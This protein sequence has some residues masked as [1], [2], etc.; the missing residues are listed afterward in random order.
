MRG[1]VSSVW[2]A[3]FGSAWVLRRRQVVRWL[4]SEHVPLLSPTLGP[5]CRNHQRRVLKFTARVTMAQTGPPMACT[6]RQ[7]GDAGG[8]GTGTHPTQ[9][10]R[11]SRVREPGAAAYRYVTDRQ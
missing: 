4:A 10:A 5:L 1:V 8:T 9:S 7:V 2:G 11:A 6:S 3:Q